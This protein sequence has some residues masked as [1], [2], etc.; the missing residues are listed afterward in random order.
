[1]GQGMRGRAAPP[2]PWEH[3]CSPCIVRRERQSGEK[4]LLGTVLTA[5]QAFVNNA[6]IFFGTKF[7]L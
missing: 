2:E 7:F 4:Y 6:T 3:T 1:M 5:K